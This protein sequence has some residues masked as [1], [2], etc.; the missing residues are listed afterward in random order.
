MKKTLNVGLVG[1]GTVGKG[2][3]KILEKNKAIALRKSG[4]NIKVKSICDLHPIDREELYVK[5]YMDVINDKTVVGNNYND[6]S[7]IDITETDVYAVLKQDPS[8]KEL[9]QYI[10]DKQ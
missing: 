7:N 8:F 3:V 9:I 5:D 4:V 6:I 2:V 1:Y 10:K